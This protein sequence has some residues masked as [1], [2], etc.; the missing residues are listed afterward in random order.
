M[1]IPEAARPVF[2]ALLV[3]ELRPITAHKKEVRAFA[4]LVARAAQDA[5]RDAARIDTC[6]RAVTDL[7][8]S[9]ERKTSPLY[10]RL[11]HA[12]AAY[13]VRTAEAGPERIWE[14]DWEAV[15]GV[16]D[17]VAHST[18]RFEHMVHPSW[19]PA[20]PATAPGG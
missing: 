2:E 15:E 20:G 6:V 3:E 18:K 19:N 16:I 12:C 4:A 13:L 10:V 7:L 9:V 17:S 8:E 1:K 5:G 11:I 14:A